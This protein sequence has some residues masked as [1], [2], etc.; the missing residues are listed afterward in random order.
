MTSVGAGSEA[1]AY[2][3]DWEDE[4]R[5]HFLLGAFSPTAAL[6]VVGDQKVQFWS[7]LVHEACRAS[8]RPV[9]SVRVMAERFNA[10]RDYY[11]QIV[12][13]LSRGRLQW[14]GQ[15]PSCLQQVLV[16]MRK[17]GQLRLVRELVQEAREQGWLSWGTSVLSRPFRWVW[18]KYLSSHNLDI[19]E[20]VYVHVQLL[21]VTQ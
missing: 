3:R 13:C 15:T 21:K 20:D 11:S 16:V 14:R 17:T 5:M 7:S 18:H 2:P 12:I 8:R 10:V 4:D 19:A 1:L 6:T 9:F